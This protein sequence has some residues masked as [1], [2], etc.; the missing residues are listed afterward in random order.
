MQKNW[1]IY[2]PVYFLTSISTRSSTGRNISYQVNMAFNFNPHLLIIWGD[3]NFLEKKSI[4][5]S[6][7]NK[8]FSLIWPKYLSLFVQRFSPNKQQKSLHQNGCSKYNGQWSSDLNFKSQDLSPA[9]TTDCSV[10]VQAP[11]QA[12][13]GTLEWWSTDHHLACL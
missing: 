10:N 2:G 3:C 13:L 11:L 9:F 8:P 1:Y 12:T 7:I 5:F 4:F 6:L